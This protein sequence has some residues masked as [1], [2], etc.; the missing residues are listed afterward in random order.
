M[1]RTLRNLARMT[2]ILRTLGRH[3]AL[4]A[5][6]L[7]DVT[8][9]YAAFAGLISRKGMPGH[10]GKRLAAALTDLGP[11]FIKLGQIVST[12]SDLVG[13]DIAADLA[14]LQDKLPPFPAHQARRIVE[15]E[16]DRPIEVLFAS[17][18]DQ[19]VAA[20]SI[21]QV[22]FATLPADPDDPGSL[23]R[24]VAVKILRPGIELA[25]RRDLD[26]IRWLADLALWFQP[27][28]KRLKPHEIVAI[29]SDTVRLE[30]DLRMEAAAAA[31]LAANFDGDPTFNVPHIDWDRTSQ[32]VLTLQRVDGVKVDEV[33][34]I[35]AAGFEP[36]DVLAKASAAF[37]NQVFR[38]G[39]FH[40]DLHPGNLFVDGA[41]NVVAVDFGIMGR[42]D[43]AT[44]T[45]LAD[46]LLGFLNG[47]YRRVAAV[48][49]QAG[50]VP[51]HQSIETFT[52]ACRA[53]GEPLLNKP[54]HEI[55]IGRLLAQLFSVTEQ[56]EM[57]TQPQLLLLQKSMLTA[58]GVGR[59]LNPNINMW[60]LVRPLIEEWM[61]ENRGPEAR[62]ADDLETALRVLR[63][64]PAALRQAERLTRML[65]D[66]GLKAHP[67]TINELVTRDGAK[68]QRIIWPVWIATAVFTAL[69]A[70]ILA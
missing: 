30:M 22:H 65:T 36:N 70:A 66:A 23:P 38:D 12:R 9:G 27:R 64:L 31:E 17:F 69:L 60:E 18:D 7:R 21:A 6:E 24:R 54:L 50:Y 45:Y 68:R 57:E 32:R 62:F 1:I 67:A 40:A 58:E 49:F 52:Q 47:D 48:H 56:F 46:M 53:I 19:P 55:S 41:G 25:F 28:L 35:R 33:E 2:V 34:R 42:L 37:F 26:L 16:F 63:D 15:N 59:A 43:R 13:E 44:R 4:F 14:E 39:F 11:S 10:P 3:D 29:F 8:P 61:R 5:D 51:P 20:A